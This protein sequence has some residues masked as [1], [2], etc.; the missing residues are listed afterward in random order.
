MEL[1]IRPI[2]TCDIVTIIGRIDS[3]T[4]PVLSEKLNGIINQGRYRIILDLSDV[5]FVSSAG[6]RV[7]IDIQKNCKKNN[8]GEVTLVNIPPRIYETLELTG[9][10]QLF[11]FYSDVG[12][13]IKAF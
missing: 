1:T 9:F 4:A 2:D 5:V 8:R 12:S 3:N 11:K 13:A 7:L 10:T 6:L